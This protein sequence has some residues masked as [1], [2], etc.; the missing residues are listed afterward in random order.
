MNKKINTK[1]MVMIAFLTSLMVV[2]GMLSSYF[3]KQTGKGILQLSEVISLSLVNT[4][5]FFILVFASVCSGILIDL[6]SGGIIYIP[7]TIVVKLLI[8]LIV[9]L[10]K[11]RITMYIVVYIA[12]LPVFIYVPY[13]W[14]TYDGSRAIQSLINECIQYTGTTVFACVFL[15]VFKNKRI[16]QY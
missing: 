1:N 9:F 4:V 6:A 15:K 13:A 3:T 7:I 12:Y 14:I 5:P 11:K 10:L 16:Y 8:F 2:L